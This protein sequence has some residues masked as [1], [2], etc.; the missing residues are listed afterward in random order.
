MKGYEK[1]KPYF[2]RLVKGEEVKLRLIAPK[3][4][5]SYGHALKALSVYLKESKP[6]KIKA[7]FKLPDGRV[8]TY[9]EDNKLIEE[10][11][12]EYSSKLFQEITERAGVATKWDG[13]WD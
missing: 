3:V 12:G 7:V 11:S 4:G 1:L 2:E 6:V 10:L 5:V 13:Q 9:G 8:E